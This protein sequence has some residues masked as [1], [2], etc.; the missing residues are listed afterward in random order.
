VLARLPPG[1]T[2]IHAGAIAAGD[3]FRG[4][5]FLMRMA[6]A[7]RRVLL[8]DWASPTRLEEF[9]LPAQLDWSMQ[10][11]GLPDKDGVE[12]RMPVLGEEPRVSLMLVF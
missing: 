5:M 10:G 12:I 3:R 11:L 4:I 6:E 1:P 9:M 7:T 8:V 2:Y